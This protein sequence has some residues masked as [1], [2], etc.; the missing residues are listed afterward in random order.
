MQKI[1]PNL[2]FDSEAEEAA[3]FYTSLFPGSETG[4]ITRYGKEGFEIHGQP[5]GAVLT[6][7]FELAGFRMTG[8]NGGPLFKFTPAISFFVVCETEAETDAL[9]QKLSES[10]KVLM[11]LGKYN[12]SE[13]Y[14]W[15]ADKYGLS[16]QI[17]LGHLQDAGQKITPSFLFVGDQYGRAEEAIDLYTSVFK[18]SEIVNIFRG[19]AAGPQGREPVLYGQFQLSG[20][21]F[22]AM[23]GA[24]EHN[25]SFT[26]GLSLMVNCGS[27][28]EVDYFWEKLTDGGEE[29]QCGWLKDKFGVSWQIVPS[30]L[31]EMMKDPDPEKVA[32]VTKAF[33]Q[34]QKFDI[35]RLEEAYQGR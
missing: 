2:W 19:E 8:L 11:E 1:I 16:W 12:W 9:W 6:V 35:R 33:L 20:E 23:D 27:Q 15:V 10:G 7:D 17:T 31:N 29:S 14:G 4:T 34:M 3:Q 21:S 30:V 25:Y 13:K 32:R 22:V 5:E 28:E 18:D 24:G 26:E